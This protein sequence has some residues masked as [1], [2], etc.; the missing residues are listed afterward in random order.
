VLGLV[1]GALAGAVAI[2]T[3]PFVI[4]GDVVDPG[5][6]YYARDDGY[7]GQDYPPR[8]AAARLL[9]SRL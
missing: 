7:Y 5:P 3:L 2:A 4:V 6:R 8:A 1:G 9:Q